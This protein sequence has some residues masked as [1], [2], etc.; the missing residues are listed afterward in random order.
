MNFVWSILERFTIMT[1]GLSLLAGLVCTIV[2]FPKTSSYVVL[3]ILSLIVLVVT[4]RRILMYFGVIKH[5]DID[6]SL[7]WEE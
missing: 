4:L 5:E 7:E 3:S 6:L 2:E 1:L